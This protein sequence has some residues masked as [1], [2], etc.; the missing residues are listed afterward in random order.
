[1]WLV[2]LF[3]V[4]LAIRIAFIYE[5]HA[6]PGFAAFAHGLDLDLQWRAADHILAGREHSFELSSLSAPLFAYVLAGWKWLAG[7]SIVAARVAIA[8]MGALRIVLVALLCRRWRLHLAGT[9]VAMALLALLPSAIYFDTMPTKVGLELF[10]LVLLLL[11]VTASSGSQLLRGGLA[12]GLLVMSFASQLN[13]CFY[14][15]P[16]AAYFVCVHQ[17]KA[18]VATAGIVALAFAVFVARDAGTTGQPG[19]FLPRAGID[20]AV[21]FHDDAGVSYRVHPDVPGNP[22]GHAFGARVSV[23]TARG[24]AVTQAEADR[25]FRDRATAWI[26]EHPGK[27]ASLIVE[28]ARFFFSNTE[29]AGDHS[30]YRLRRHSLI[31]RFA[32]GFGCVLALAAAGI[33][34]C[35]RERQRRLLVLLVGLVAVQLAVACVTN[36]NW[37]YRIPALIPLV[38]LA[39]IGIDHLVRTWRERARRRLV[40]PL[41]AVALGAIVA[42][43]SVD[44]AQRGRDLAFAREHELVVKAAQ[45]TVAA[46]ETSSGLEHAMQLHELSRY[47]EAYEQLAASEPQLARHPAAARAYLEYLLAL[48]RRDRVQALLARWPVTTRAAV[49]QPRGTPYDAALARLASDP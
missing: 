13:T 23:E 4:A 40:A 14:V 3:V 41:V 20:L 22:F 35:W 37:R 25:V 29:L 44:A 7:D 45:R 36:L 5:T 18:A 33:V 48:G 39:G 12:G 43:T 31:A 16:V 38:L 10:V 30:L 28:R 19:W 2:L 17:R 49:R 47:T 42:F 32:L 26:A 11:V 6:V 24:E 21:G 34:A 9:V 8:V 15:V 27:A 46:M 1:M